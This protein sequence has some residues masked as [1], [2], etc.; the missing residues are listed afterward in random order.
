MMN[1]EQ[2]HNYKDIKNIDFA[3]WEVT[4]ITVYGVWKNF[5]PQFVHSLCGFEKVDE[6]S[7]E[8]FSN[9]MTLWEKLK[10]DLQ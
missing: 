8:T 6:E 1:Q 10:L 5:G 4:A 2:T 3:W 7:K 9:L